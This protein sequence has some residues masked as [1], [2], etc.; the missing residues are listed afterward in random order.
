MLW[1]RGLLFTIVMYGAALVLSATELLIFWAPHRWIAQ[2]GPPLH[3]TAR[4]TAH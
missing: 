4:S 2:S 1:F 3:Q